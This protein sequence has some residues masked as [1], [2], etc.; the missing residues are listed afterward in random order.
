MLILLLACDP[1]PV[2]SVDPSADPGRLDSVPFIPD[3]GDDSGTPGGESGDTGFQYEVDTVTDVIVVGSGPAGVAA[4]LAATEA[5]ARVILFERDDEPGTGLRLAGSAFGVATPW[6]A[7]AGIADSVDLAV[8]EW[9]GITGEAGDQES[10]RNYF[11]WSS[12]TLEWLVARGWQIGPVLIPPSEGSVARIHVFVW[13]DSITPYQQ[14]MG[15]WTG[16]LR[17]EVEVTEPLMRDGAVVGVRW[18][19][20][21]TGEEGATGAS[22]VV[23]ASGGF[24][25]DLDAVAEVRPDLLDHNVVFETNPN[26]VGSTLPFLVQAGAGRLHPE[27]IGTYLHSVEDPARPGEALISQGLMRY[28]L[29][30][31][32]GRRFTADGQLGAFGPAN[33]APP[34]DLW[35][36]AGG[37]DPDQV[38]LSPPGYNWA[39]ENQPERLTMDQVIGEGSNDVFVAD[40]LEDLAAQTGLGDA[41]VDEVTTFNEEAALGLTDEFGRELS[42]KDELD[43]AAWVALRVSPGLA[44]NFGGVATDPEAHVLTPEGM[45]VPG[46]YAAGEVAGMI[47]GGGAGTGYSGSSSACY[48]GGILAGTNAAA[49]ALAR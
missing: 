34:G 35:L 6:Q 45:P 20:V 27:Q 49:E 46:L 44:K 40:T 1:S 31:A 47:P 22:T 48:Y 19:N 13:S 41:L 14:V 29:V 3:P 18:R 5:G 32:D 15:A 2:E 42:S 12:A 21:A 17:T 24:L 37:A 25:R 9:P 4:S 8:T 16:E 43:G 28:I 26:S 7:A 10:V 38:R 33:D 23:L 30:G 36:I 11:T 39:V